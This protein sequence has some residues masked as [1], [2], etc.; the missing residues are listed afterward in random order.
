MPI[1]EA[2]LQK[3]NR[4]FQKVKEVLRL[5]VAAVFV[6]VVVV[7]AHLYITFLLALLV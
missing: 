4:F 3:V 5:L 2:F 1:I 6:V 7:V